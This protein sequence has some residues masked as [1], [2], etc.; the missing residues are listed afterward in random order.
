MPAPEGG[1]VQYVAPGGTGSTAL[2]QAVPELGLTAGADQDAVAQ[3]IAQQL[4]KKD[5]SVDFTAVPNFTIG[6]L[7]GVFPVPTS[8]DSEP[9]QSGDLI[10][11]DSD[12]KYYRML[13]GATNPRDLASWEEISV[14]TSGLQEWPIAG[15]TYGT[16]AGR[17]NK[18]V[19]PNTGYIYLAQQPT[20][21]DTI[22][23]ETDE[24]T[25]W[26]AALPSRVDALGDI[27]PSATAI[28]QINEYST[29][30][31][32]QFQVSDS[33]VAYSYRRSGLEIVTPDVLINGGNGWVQINGGV[34]DAEGFISVQKDFELE[35][36]GTR[37]YRATL[38]HR[39][40]AN[41]L[42]FKFASTFG[43]AQ[44]ASTFATN[45]R[46]YL[47]NT[48]I[49]R[50]EDD[51][52]IRNHGPIPSLTD[53]E[54]VTKFP[55]P[56]IVSPGDEVTAADT[57]TVYKYREG[58]TDPLAMVNWKSLNGVSA[59]AFDAR[60]ADISDPLVAGE[61]FTEI[62]TDLTRLGRAWLFEVPAGLAGAAKGA[63]WDQTEEARYTAIGDTPAPP[64]DGRIETL[65]HLGLDNANQVIRLNDGSL[66]SLGNIAVTANITGYGERDI[67]PVY[68]K[69]FAF[70][71]N[72][73]TSAD[74][75]NASYQNFQVRLNQVYT[76]RRQIIN[77]TSSGA[78]N[79]NG[80]GAGTTGEFTFEKPETTYT[81]ANSFNINE[82][83]GVRTSI[84]DWQML[85]EEFP[86][87]I[88]IDGVIP[89]V[90]DYV[91]FTSS[92]LVTLGL[93][94]SQT[95]YVVDRNDG[96]TGWR[97]IPYAPISY[98]DL[99]DRPDIPNQLVDIG[100][101][102]TSLQLDPIP[103]N[104]QELVESLKTLA[105]QPIDRVDARAANEAPVAGKINVYETASEVPALATFPAVDPDQAIAIVFR[106]TGINRVY[107][108]TADG[109]AWE[110]LPESNT[111]NG[112]RGEPVADIPAL[113]ALTARNF[114]LRLV[115]ATDNEYVFRSGL[116]AVAPNLADDAA[117]GAWVLQTP[118]AD[119]FDFL[120]YASTTQ[121]LEAVGQLNEGLTY[122][123][124]AGAFPTDAVV[125]A[126]VIV[127]AAGAPTINGTTAT[128]VAG[129]VFQNQGTADNNNWQRV[130]SGNP[131]QYPLFRD[132]SYTRNLAGNMQIEPETLN[133]VSA[134]GFYPIRVLSTD[135]GAGGVTD[136]IEYPTNSQTLDVNFY[137]SKDSADS[138]FITIL[139][140]VNRLALIFYPKLGEIQ[141]LLDG[142]QDY[143]RVDGSDLTLV[144]GA[145]APGD[146]GNLTLPSSSDLGTEWVFRLTTSRSGSELA[147]FNLAP[148]NPPAPAGPDNTGLVEFTFKN[149]SIPFAGVPSGSYLVTQTSLIPQSGVPDNTVVDLGY[150]HGSAGGL[151]SFTIPSGQQVI[152]GGVSFFR[153]GTIDPAAGTY[154][155]LTATSGV[156]NGLTEQVDITVNS[157]VSAA[158]ELNITEQSIGWPVVGTVG[159]N[160]FS[161]SGDILATP[162]ASITAS[163]W[164]GYLDTNGGN[165]PMVVVRLFDSAG[166]EIP[167]S[168]SAFDASSTG[169]FD[170]AENN[171]GVYVF[172]GD[173]GMDVP[174]LVVTDGTVP[175]D[176][177][178]RI[179]IYTNS[180][181]TIRDSSSFNAL[182]R[183]VSSVTIGSVERIQVNHTLT[184][185]GATINADS[186]RRLTA[187][188][189]TVSE[190]FDNLVIL[191]LSPGKVLDTATAGTGTVNIGG[192]S[193]APGIARISY[194]PA[195]ADDTLTI[196]EKDPEE[197]YSRRSV[198]VVSTGSVPN[199]NYGQAIA[200]ANGNSLEVPDVTALANYIQ[201]Q[202]I[203]V[204]PGASVDLECYVTGYAANNA[205]PTKIITIAFDAVTNLPLTSTDGSGSEGSQ[206]YGADSAHQTWLRH[207]TFGNRGYQG[208]TNLYL[209]GPASASI[210][211]RF[212]PVSTTRMNVGHDQPIIKIG[213]LANL[214]IVSTDRALTDHILTVQG[215]GTI[216]SNTDGFINVT[217][218]RI[219]EGFSRDVYFDMGPGQEI[220][221]VTGNNI[222]WFFRA[223]YD[224]NTVLAITA[225][226]P[227]PTINLTTVDATSF[228]ANQVY[229]ELLWEDP[230]DGRLDL[231][232]ADQTIDLGTDLRQF[233]HLIV[234]FHDQTEAT[235]QANRWYKSERMPIPTHDG[236]SVNSAWRALLLAYDQ[237]YVYFEVNDTTIGSIDVREVTRAQTLMKIWGVRNT[238]KPV[239]LIS[240]VAVTENGN[241]F[242]PPITIQENRTGFVK[243]PVTA[244]M[245]IAT[246]SAPA[247]TSIAIV[248]NTRDT[249]EVQALTNDIDIT[250]T[251]QA[252][253]ATDAANGILTNSASKVVST[254][255]WSLQWDFSGA[256][257]IVTPTS[258]TDG[259][260]LALT[261]TSY[262]FRFNNT[263]DHVVTIELAENS[264]GTGG[265]YQ[266]Y[267]FLPTGATVTNSAGTDLT[268][269]GSG[270][271]YQTYGLLWLGRMSSPAIAKINVTDT[272]QRYEMR[273]LE[274]NSSLSMRPNQT[275]ILLARTGR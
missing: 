268:P 230:T 26:R 40:V 25:H 220:S 151:V 270:I 160:S 108:P 161:E 112:L 232:G 50:S 216:R 142:G 14:A 89:A 229:Q 244:G 9:A 133:W 15:A 99:A 258:D 260:D 48:E 257:G 126:A 29:I 235:D 53:A 44:G 204:T 114:E 69:G 96:T 56:T 37:W 98:N 145:Q 183:T 171:G 149:N 218:T 239:S 271:Y 248:A 194:T 211:V 121:Q 159:T 231:T 168:T 202:P 109:T 146:S 275:R 86:R 93:P 92:F 175:G 61:K 182:V 261:E 156:I 6:S 221:T 11:I 33:R 49:V 176:G 58:A 30:E 105:E 169:A 66:V 83:S 238:P 224:G 256:D 195:T 67:A 113:T 180:F 116:A 24:G 95:V 170:T 130:I 242:S 1:L 253:P 236:F 129:D 65:A 201:S 178:V 59:G 57:S 64:S 3:A 251:E 167:S 157:I 259:S 72:V 100:F 181:T 76:T 241:A 75:Q 71:G 90:G 215:G 104:A 7:T 119:A 34:A 148:L 38:A 125:N 84:N 205:S 267:A 243:L 228:Q 20:I 198:R 158:P 101:D 28:N 184:V 173:R 208:T 127:R 60:W 115:L 136:N 179:R 87:Q 31:S 42:E 117:T 217:Q 200:N 137:I 141:W 70:D 227:N 46:T 47:V 118:V 62:S 128:V 52:L 153:S 187:T 139:W 143:V 262:Q 152:S 51:N 254:G 45:S 264:G 223:N 199:D 23:P 103:A 212:Y 97:L 27:N 192:Y 102:N 247:A 54:L 55:D 210:Y 91:E 120:Y 85:A 5:D 32:I 134:T 8:G 233:T 222:D 94:I 74:M 245:Q 207:S 188:T 203:A 22:D 219:L 111:A 81:G 2:T 107:I 252:Q 88:D 12:G 106:D 172:R 73:A 17:I 13:P 206:G 265:Q 226:G 123:D 18:V 124:L 144:A 272:T 189:Q 274:Q 80:F 237:G 163:A 273:I 266:F 214:T 122:V 250:W 35:G 150:I 225:T 246:V 132:E 78:W 234:D 39:V 43:D 82:G 154:T 10:R 131:L 186:P 135:F 79:L 209:T 162:G 177:V 110:L 249:V 196:T 193:P 68:N 41:V 140:G 63:L 174:P 190:Q 77:A 164:G 155:A 197:S 16:D 138:V 185:S 255:D 165:W 191:D 213:E 263:G 21:A 147:S 36:D 269:A 4:A 19:G 240:T 166:S